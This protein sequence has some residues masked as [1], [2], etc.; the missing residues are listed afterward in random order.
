MIAILGDLHLR[1]DK[2]YWR[3]TCEAFLEWYR[4]WPTNCKGNDLILTGDL[5]ETPVLSGTVVD[6]LE[7]LVEWSNFDSIHICVGNHD[8]KKMNGH[9]QIAYKFYNNKKKVH[10]Y[11]EI[12]SIDISGKSVLMLPY[13]L[14]TNSHKQTMHDFYSSIWNDKKFN[15]RY[16]LVVGHLCGSDCIFPGDTNY[17]DNLE[18]INADHVILGHVHTRSVNSKRYIGSIFANKKSENDKTR[19]AVIIRDD[20]SR[21]E[22]KL[23]VF[24]EFIA[25]NYPNELPKTDAIVPIYSVLSCA[26][27][28]V[29]RVKYGDIFIRRT[30]PDISDY[31][32]KRNVQ[33]DMRL[34][35]VQE[36]DVHEMFKSF[37]K[38]QTPPFSNLIEEDCFKMLA[39]RN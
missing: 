37:C 13:F 11:D 15:K 8:R 25:I 23:P 7:K 6:Y 18:K 5:V 31:I 29:A 4:N 27:E 3:A 24:N 26:S 36:M 32:P 12:A 2:P 30:T 9:E 19:A 21:Y 16:D 34:D 39:K 1:D 33:L 38:N 22:E 35:S 10:L 20:N 28:T 14:G 17:V